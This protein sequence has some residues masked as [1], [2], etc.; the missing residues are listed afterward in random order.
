MSTLIV[1]QYCIL[2]GAV[3]L[4]AGV[5]IGHL[6]GYDSGFRDAAGQ[7]R[8]EFQKILDIEERD[9]AHAAAQ[10][11]GKCSYCRTVHDLRVACP[12]QAKVFHRG[13]NT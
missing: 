1:L 2:T 9:D 10:W 7:C 3:A 11:Y 6:V 8:E 4:L 5:F 13:E 12:E